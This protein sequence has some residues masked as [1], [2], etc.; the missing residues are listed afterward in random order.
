MRRASQWAFVLPHVRL[1][2]QYD[3][4][5]E[6]DLVAIPE[7]DQDLLTQVQVVP[8]D[9]ELV[10]YMT[11]DLRPVIWGF[12]EDD[13]PYG[14]PTVADE[15]LRALGARERIRNAIVG[16]YNLWI[17]RRVTWRTSTPPSSKAA[18]KAILGL[19]N[20][21]ADLHVLTDGAF[22]PMTTLETIQEG[23]NP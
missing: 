12:V 1:K 3:M 8:R 11:W 4:R 15:T 5:R 9:H 2:Y 14:G 10:L 18:I 16:L 17:E 21:E 13:S 7:L 23:G 20:I 6:E 22:T 19:Q